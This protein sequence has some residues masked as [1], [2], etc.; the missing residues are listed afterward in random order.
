MTLTENYNNLILP[1]IKTGVIK[2]IKVTRSS[3]AAYSETNLDFEFQLSTNVA[4]DG[5]ILIQFPNEVLIKN[6]ITNLVIKRYSDNTYSTEI[7]DISGS[8]TPLYNAK[9][10]L[11][12]IL[13]GSVCSGDCAKDAII[14]I[15]VSKLKNNYFITKQDELLRIATQDNQDYVLDSASIKNSQII[16]QIE[17]SDIKTATVTRDILFF[18]LESTYSFVIEFTDTQLLES[19]TKVR[20]TL[21]NTQLLHGGNRFYLEDKAN[22]KIVLTKVENQVAKKQYMMEFTVES[23]TQKKYE[24]KLVGFQNAITNP[25]K[26]IANSIFIELYT[27]NDE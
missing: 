5:K 9:T 15:R 21:P 27:K 17:P 14:Y 18:T 13:I 22:K 12:Q 26:D 20:I 1:L 25:T 3:K 8:A 2:G 24:F 10:Y 6:G 11:Q 19:T 23:N 16:N 4:N 7:R